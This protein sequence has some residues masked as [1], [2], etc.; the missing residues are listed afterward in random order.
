MDLSLARRLGSIPAPAVARAVVA[1]CARTE[2]GV[3]RHDNRAIAA[4]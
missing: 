4:A 1:L 2:P 3:F